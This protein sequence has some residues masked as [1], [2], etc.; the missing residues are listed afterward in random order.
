MTQP[1]PARTCPEEKDDAHSS[2]TQNSF[3][4]CMMEEVMRESDVVPLAVAV[5]EIVFRPIE[6]QDKE[7]VK[8]LHEEWFPVRSVA[9]CLDAACSIPTECWAGHRYEDSFYER[10]VNSGDTHT[11]YYTM[12]A[13]LQATGEIVGECTS[14]VPFL[15]DCVLRMNAGR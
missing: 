3:I 6:P 11:P 2:V 7:A 8:F 5:S 9:P 1:P 12:A 15:G 4:G 14:A 10:L 13:V